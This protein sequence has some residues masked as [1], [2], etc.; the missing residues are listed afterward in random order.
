MHAVSMAYEC[1]WYCENHGLLMPLSL[2]LEGTTGLDSVGEPFGFFHFAALTLPLFSSFLP[3]TYY[4][5][6]SPDALAV[7]GSHFMT[8]CLGL[9]AMGKMPHNILCGVRGG[10]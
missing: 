7:H 1:P 3:W 10:S 8:L 2:L 5:I 4:R 9:S 6:W